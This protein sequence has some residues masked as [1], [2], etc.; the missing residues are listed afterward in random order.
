MDGLQLKISLKWMIWGYPYFR[1]PRYIYIYIYTYIYIYIYVF[2]NRLREREREI[3]VEI[4]IYIYLYTSDTS[5]QRV[6]SSVQPGP[7][8]PIAPH[9]SSEHARMS[10]GSRRE[11][12]HWAGGCIYFKEWEKMMT[13][14]GLLM[15]I[16]DY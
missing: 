9:V 7:Q 14:C 5:T 12:G 13:S 6:G 8:Q 1:K 3:R 11:R 4:Y 2:I 15:V 16:S 10:L